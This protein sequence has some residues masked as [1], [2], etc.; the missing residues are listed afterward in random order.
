MRNVRVFYTK[1]GRMRFVSHLDMNRF[2]TRALRKTNISFW[3]TEGFNPH[4]Y[5]AFPL[6]LS[7]GFT[8]SYEIVEFKVLDDNMSLESVAAELGRV[9]PP[10]IEILYAGENVMKAGAVGFA[11]YT[12]TFKESLAKGFAEFLTTDKAVITKT[13]KRG[14]TV[15]INVYEKVK[16]I[17]VLSDTSVSLILPAGNDNVNPQM[18]VETFLGDKTDALSVEINRDIIYNSELQPFI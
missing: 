12:L 8:S 4:P 13:S 5:I 15:T 18:V 1:K 17:E 9:M 2:F 16:E 6:P 7:L 10:D 14:N 11:K 3:Y